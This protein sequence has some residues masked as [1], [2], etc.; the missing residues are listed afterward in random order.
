MPP[1]FS[2][3]YLLRTDGTNEPI[4][5]LRHSDDI[6]LVYIKENCEGGGAES[7]T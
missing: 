2:C 7:N 1:M 3:R 5:N 6:L 4:L